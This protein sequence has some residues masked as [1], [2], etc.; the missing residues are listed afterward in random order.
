M[1]YQINFGADLE[2]AILINT[3]GAY[4]PN[5]SKL[6]TYQVVILFCDFTSVWGNATLGDSGFQGKQTIIDGENLENNENVVVKDY[7]KELGYETAAKQMEELEDFLRPIE[8]LK[9]AS[10]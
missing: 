3:E 7:L 8:E 4:N 5:E 1:K 2:Q 9:E 6:T 10:R